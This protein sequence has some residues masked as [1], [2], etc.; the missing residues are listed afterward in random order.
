LLQL[1]PTIHY[2]THNHENMIVWG[3]DYQEGKM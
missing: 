3:D 1:R 2:Q